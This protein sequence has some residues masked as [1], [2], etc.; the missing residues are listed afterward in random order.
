M[1]AQAQAICSLVTRFIM[2]PA[3]PVAADKVVCPSV[4]PLAADGRFCFSS[5]NE[6]FTLC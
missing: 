1:S 5:N 4:H 6:L 3:L 2:V